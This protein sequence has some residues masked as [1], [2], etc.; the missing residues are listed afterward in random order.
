MSKY[1][2]KKIT[3]DG[4]TFD[5]KKEY[6]RYKE[7]VLLEKARVIENLQCQVKFNLLPSY[8]ETY[9]RYSE[10]TGRR[11]KDGTR[12]VERECNYI[13]DFVYY[14]NGKMVVE[15]TKGFATP[16]FKIKKKLMLWVHGIKVK[17]L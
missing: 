15:D 16:D 8:V 6:R 14:E 13:A 17:V 11:I 12:T 7:L 4:R 10:K 3:V 9:P 1:H 5:S 2:A